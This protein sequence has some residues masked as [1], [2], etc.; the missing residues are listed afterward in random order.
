MNDSFTLSPVCLLPL[1]TQLSSTQR[2]HCQHAVLSMSM[3][4]DRCPQDHLHVLLRVKIESTWSVSARSG[5]ALWLGV[6][7][8][9]A[10]DISWLIVP[11]VTAAA[12]GK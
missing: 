2:E 6:G 12:A 7:R 11:S 3:A 5:M 9:A 8:A 10:I 4:M 1:P